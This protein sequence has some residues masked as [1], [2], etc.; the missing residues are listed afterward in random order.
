MM[1]SCT[2]QLSLQ[3]EA[4]LVH[5]QMDFHLPTSWNFVYWESLRDRN[6]S[7][8]CPI[9][10]HCP[11]PCE[12]E[13]L[14]QKCVSLASQ[15]VAIS[16]HGSFCMVSNAGYWV[17]CNALCSQARLKIGQSL[18]HCTFAHCCLSHPAVLWP[19][20]LLTS[21]HLIPSLCHNLIIHLKRTRLFEF[22]NNFL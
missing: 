12:Q 5:V 7:T 10:I 9:V 16:E 11:L 8:K 22:L 17:K 20:L 1:P 6:E 13:I 3:N 15:Q 2:T 19:P 4:V 14:E 18:V 21:K